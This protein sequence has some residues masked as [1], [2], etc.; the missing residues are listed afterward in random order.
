MSTQDDVG[1]GAQLIQDAKEALTRLH[2]TQ[3]L[4]DWFVYGRAFMALRVD[5]M[6]IAKTNDPKGRKYSMAMSTLL[7]EAGLDG[8]H[9][10]TR[11]RL[12]EV[13][14]NR[15][16]IETWLTTVPPDRR[17]R[18]NHPEPVLSAW[19]RAKGEKKPK[20]EPKPELCAIW[21]NASTEEQRAALDH[22]G[23]DLL[24]KALSPALR[25]EVEHRLVNP[26][27]ERRL[28]EK[29]GEE[30]QAVEE[31]KKGIKARCPQLGTASAP[32]PVKSRQTPKSVPMTNIGS[33]RR[34]DLETLRAAIAQE[35]HRSAYDERAKGGLT[36]KEFERLDKMKKQEKILAKTAAAEGNASVAARSNGNDVSTEQ[37][38]AAM[39]AARA[40]RE[41]AG[42]DQPAA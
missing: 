34:F 39:M 28:D 16:E 9:K 31:A 23:I 20:P 8:V 35:Q 40:A 21:K 37:S 41:A 12:K 7:K 32:E 36:P 24:L 22:G 2:R 15:A 11:S 25:A 3:L 5:A 10:T 19:K 30:K 6:R 4:P 1:C 29:D 17:L 33:W 26:H 13:M 38:T 18:L 27:T 14:E 42:R